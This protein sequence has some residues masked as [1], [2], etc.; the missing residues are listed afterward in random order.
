MRKQIETSY[1]KTVLLFW[2]LICSLCSALDVHVASTCSTGNLYVLT[3]VFKTGLE[4]Y[5]IWE[6]YF[7]YLPLTEIINT[8][9]HVTA[10]GRFSL[11]TQQI[12]FTHWLL[13]SPSVSS[14]FLIRYVYDVIAHHNVTSSWMK[15][16]HWSTLVSGL[17]FQRLKKI[18][19]CN[20]CCVL[21]A[22]CKVKIHEHVH[23][24]NDYMHVYDIIIVYLY[25]IM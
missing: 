3:R 13:A 23:E 12:I 2:K 19:K 8:H 21:R 7:G 9:L 14:F 6:L 5:Y 11:I 18:S 10:P 1:W 4:R 20:V 17:N 15:S 22:G 16:N 24:S 25:I